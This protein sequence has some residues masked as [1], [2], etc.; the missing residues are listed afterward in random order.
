MASDELGKNYQQ[1][2]HEIKKE[3]ELWRL[4]TGIDEYTPKK[5]DEHDRYTYASSLKRDTFKPSV[6]EYL[7]LVYLIMTVIF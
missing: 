5:L 6:S 1:V 7:H 3:K 2:Y 4:F